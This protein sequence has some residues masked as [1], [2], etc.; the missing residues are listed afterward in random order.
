V[1]SLIG[2]ALWFVARL[3]ETGSGRRARPASLRI[4]NPRFT[5]PSGFM[6]PR[7]DW[8][9]AGGLCRSDSGEPMEW[10]AMSM[11]DACMP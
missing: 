11:L 9:S 4:R 6:D 2:G 1:R 10:F 7:W 5:E 8:G 3:E